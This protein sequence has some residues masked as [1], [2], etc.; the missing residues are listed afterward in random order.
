LEFLRI[1]GVKRPRWFLWENVPGVLSSCEGRDFGAFLGAVQKCGYGF[2]Y[3]VLDA[4]HFGVPQRRRRVFVVGYLG[5]WKPAAAVL[6]DGQ[7]VLRD[8]PTLEEGDESQETTYG[9]RAGA[10]GGSERDLKRK[11][12]TIKAGYYKCYNDNE[13]MDNLIIGRKGTKTT[14]RRL[15]PR[16]CELLQGFPPDYTRISWKNRSAEKCP[17]GL[18]YKAVGNSMA[19]PVMRWIG[20]R[21]AAVDSQQR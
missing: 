14:I 4:Q 8:T 6:F 7:N 13:N 21:I 5:D 9:A 15:T 20:T 12:A 18:R 1:A 11:A 2:A 10:Q 19:V 3:R 16:E 17:D